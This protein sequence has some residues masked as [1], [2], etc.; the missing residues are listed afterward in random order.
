M[1]QGALRVRPERP[2]TLP[3]RPREGLPIMSLASPAVPASSPAFPGGMDVRLSGDLSRGHWGARRVLDGS[4]QVDLERGGVRLE[5][6]ARRRLEP[7]C[8][9]GSG[10]GGPVRGAALP[11][12]GGVSDALGEG[13]GLLL[14]MGLDPSPPPPAAAQGP[15]H[16]TPQP[17][18][19]LCTPPRFLG[20]CFFWRVP[21]CTSCWRGSVL[22]PALGSQI[23]LPLMSP[24]EARLGN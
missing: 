4:F 12:K 1:P 18:R 2:E 23:S 15:A 8:P 11:R 3:S 13:A 19:A 20:A 21:S 10:M 9:R 16:P 17:G 7:P 6:E 24:S 14:R 5:T 22:P